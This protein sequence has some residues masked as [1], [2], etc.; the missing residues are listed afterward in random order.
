MPKTLIKNGT[1]ISMDPDIEDMPVGDLLIEDDRI[2][3]IGKGIRAEDADVMDAS[4]MI[5]LP[6]LINAHIHTWTTALRGLGGN[7]A[8]WDFFRTVHRNLAPRYTPE[9]SYLSTLIGALNQVHGGTTTLFEW[10]HNNKTPAHTDAT[11]D[12]L[13]DSDIRAVFGHGTVKPKPKEG[14]P[15]FSEIPHPVEEIKR[16]RTGRLAIDDARVTPAVAILGPDYATL[17]VTLHDFRLAREYGLLSSAHIWGREDRRVKEGYHRIARE[18]LLGPDHNVVHGNYLNDDELRVIVD[19]G[20]SVTSTPNVELQKNPV[21]TLIGRV[22]ALGGRPSIGADHEINLSGDMFHVMRYALQTQRIFDN[23]KNAEARVPIKELSVHARQ[24]LEW[25]TIN[26]AKA[27]QLE[28]RIGSLTPGKQADITMIRTDGI[29][30]ISTNDPVQTVVFYANCSNVD[31]VF[32]AGRKV[33]SNGEL[34]YSHAELERKKEQ[35]LGSNRR[36][37]QEAGLV[38]KVKTNDN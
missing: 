36:L 23:L 29:N 27:L 16:L 22:H 31:T 11:I 1:I 30:T 37:M 5:V 12:A 21:E 38:V 19:S 3:D 34:L 8:G 13:F 6:G 14:E 17:E 4:N 28:D 32:I 18:G 20:A 25:A 2:S 7:W 9:D 35:L 15:H 10:C 33:K 26:N 24:A